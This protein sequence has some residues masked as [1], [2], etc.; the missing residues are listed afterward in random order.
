MTRIF[1]AWLLKHVAS[2]LFYSGNFAKKA[3]EFL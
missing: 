1:G 2:I 3:I